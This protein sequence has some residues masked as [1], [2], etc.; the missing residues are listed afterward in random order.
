VCETDHF[1]RFVAAMVKIYQFV[2]SKK[3]TIETGS[4]LATVSAGCDKTMFVLAAHY[5]VSVTSRLAK[6]I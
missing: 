1:G 2:V 5:D 3:F 6:N 4:Y